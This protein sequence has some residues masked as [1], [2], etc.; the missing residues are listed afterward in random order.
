MRRGKNEQN[1]VEVYLCFRMHYTGEMYVCVFFV[2]EMK[3]K[4]ME[5]LYTG[6]SQYSAYAVL[7]KKQAIVECSF[8]VLVLCFCRCS[9]GCLYFVG[10]KFRRTM[11]I[12]ARS[13]E[14]LGIQCKLSVTL[15][16]SLWH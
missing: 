4:Q 9:W 14:K 1:K 6:Y 7:P 12:G 11:S 13:E 5:N 2:E 15:C 16:G 3:K 10:L 8:C